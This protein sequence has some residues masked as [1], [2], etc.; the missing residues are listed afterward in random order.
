MIL[1]I[2]ERLTLLTILPHEGDYASLKI[3]NQLRLS[4]SFT[5][6]E[7]KEWGIIG[8]PEKN[9]TSWANPNETDSQEAEIPI[10]EKATDIIVEALK[11]LDS[12]K[13]L[14]ENALEVYEKFIP[15]T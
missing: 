1:D 15:T 14:P 7:I 6:E 10:G 13:K 8:D 11:K 4:L 12:E 9:M 2:S 5:E 3:L